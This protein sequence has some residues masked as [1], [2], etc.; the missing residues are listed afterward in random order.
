MHKSFLGSGLFAVVA[1]L[2]LAGS[3]FGQWIEPQR[4]SEAASPS[5]GYKGARLYAAQ[6][7]GFHAVYMI[8]AY[9]GVR[10]KRFD[11]GALSGPVTLYN[12]FCANAT[13][14]E[15]LNGDIHVAMERGVGD[16][17]II[18]ANKS[19]NGGASFAGWQN[20][21]GWPHSK[22]PHITPVGLTGDDML[23]TYYQADGG[24]INYWIYNGS[25][26]SSE[27]Y[28]GAN[29]LSGYDCFGQAFSPLDGTVWRAYNPTDM[30]YR[31][32]QYNGGWGNEQVIH[33]NLWAVRQHMAVNDAG[34]V[35]LLYEQWDAGM[36][37]LIQ[38][39]AR[40]YTPG[41]GF[42]PVMN[43]G[44]GGYNGSVDICAIPGSNDF[45][46]ARTDNSR[47]YGKRYTNGQW[48]AEELISGSL[49]P[50]FTVFPSLTAGADGTV[51]CAW[52]HWVDH[53]DYG[54]PE[55]WFAVRPAYPYIAVNPA[56]ISRSVNIS[57]NL[58]NSV[59]TLSNAGAGTMSYT[60]S[61]DVSWL[62][63]ANPTGSLG[64]AGST[65][66]T[67][68]YS[69][70]SLS[71]GAYSANVTITAP[72]AFNTPVVLPVTVNVITVE[73]DLDADGDVD[74][75]DFGIMQA[76]FTGS[77]VNAEPACQPA[78]FDTDYDV[79]EDDVTIF[80]GCFSGPNH[81]AVPTCVP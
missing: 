57:N 25:S 46:F 70:A 17:L 38:V 71:A 7:G 44:G 9:D 31:M 41:A 55:Q 40:L 23:L 24:A 6:G 11:G 47:V 68:V 73:P 20:L 12:G 48:L 43:M 34:Q 29:S 16:D 1:A 67:L 42:G 56:S 62:S 80:Q 49:P 15:A 2:M 64:P 76:C 53:P 21:N 30:T 77:Q 52:E 60:V 58:S 13:V 37:G 32:R 79:D 27:M 39:S 3:A 33:T 35:M 50:N 59:L 8:G 22:S 26:W 69:V 74:S 45:Y 5:G 72:S 66:I 28:T 54:E 61:D 63:V 65:P 18:A 4:L 19:T 51:Y 75:T 10:Y 81:V 14:A 78:S 36:A